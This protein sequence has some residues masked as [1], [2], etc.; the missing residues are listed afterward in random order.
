MGR[1][2]TTILRRYNHLDEVRKLIFEDKVSEAEQLASSMMGNP[3]L[4]MPYQPFCDLR[5]HFS[6]DPQATEYHRDL[7]LENAISD[8]AYKIGDVSFL[9]ESFVSYPDQVLVI[10]LTASKPGQLTFSVGM[11]SPQTGT[12]VTSGEDG[13]LHLVGQIQ[14]R[15]NKPSSWTGSWDQ[16]ETRFAAALK[17]LVDGGSVH[18]SGD[19]LDISG[20]NSVT[21]LFSNATSFKDFRDI[22]GDPVALAQGCLDKAVQK[23]YAQLR[24]DHIAD[25]A[26]LF[27]RVRLQLGPT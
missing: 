10:R 4:L 23:S 7:N 26:R 5:L 20:A 15:Q 9:R 16:P 18:N 6:G 27:S 22:G 14:P 21:I 3:K 2:T 1:T 13:S 19:H 11:D 25:Y 24:R 12:T 8:T 17:V